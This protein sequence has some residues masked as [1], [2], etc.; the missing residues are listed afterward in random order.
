MTIKVYGNREISRVVFS[1]NPTALSVWL[2]KRNDRS[3]ILSALP[4]AFVEL[5]SRKGWTK[6][7]IEGWAGQ[8]DLLCDWSQLDTSGS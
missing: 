2:K 6:E 1:G 4:V 8:N 5:G 3:K 7:Q